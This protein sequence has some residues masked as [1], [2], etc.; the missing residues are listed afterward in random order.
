M[1]NETPNS[2]T[3]TLEYMHLSKTFEYNY[4]GNLTAKSTENPVLFH[5]HSFSV[6]KF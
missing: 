6:L 5:D 2:A 4:D 1:S 3:Q